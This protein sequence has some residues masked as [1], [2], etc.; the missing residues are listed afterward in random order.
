MKLFATAAIAAGLLTAG[1]AGAA[2]NL[3]GNG[4][5]EALPL[6]FKWDYS[7]VGY[8]GQDASKYPVKVIGYNNNNGYNDDPAGAYGELVPPD[9][10]ASDSPDTVGTHAAYFVADNSVETLSQLVHLTGGRYKVG[11][12][13]Y[14]PQNGVNNP[15]DAKFTGSIGSDVLA[16]FS[17]KSGGLTPKTWYNYSGV[18]T[19]ATGD[20]LI[21]FAYDSRPAGF[22]A[23]VVVDRVYAIAVPEPASWALMIAGFGSAGAMIR[24]R[25]AA[26]A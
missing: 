22:G 26:I 24:R 18:K 14:L 6:G 19:F 21:S 13:V 8:G 23:D 11:F 3:V 16:S 15:I 25:K 20:Y 2:T 12:S 17:A 5:F 4:S 7:G 10:S 1:A 9:N